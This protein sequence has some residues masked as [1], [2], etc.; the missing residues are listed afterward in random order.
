MARLGTA[1]YLAYQIYRVQ[2]TVRESLTYRFVVPG[3]FVSVYFQR[4]PR[5]LVYILHFG[6]SM[7]SLHEMVRYSDTNWI[8]QY[9]DLHQQRT[10]RP[11][12]INVLYKNTDLALIPGAAMI[13][14]VGILTGGAVYNGHHIYSAAR[15]YVMFPGETK[16]T[17]Y[18][19]TDLPTLITDMIKMLTR[20]KRPYADSVYPVSDKVLRIFVQSSSDSLSPSDSDSDHS[21]TA[22]DSSLPVM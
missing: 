18:A 15:T 12:Q 2:S 1:R 13:N 8:L 7:Y 20:P 11:D 4:I 5:Y 14:R 17:P 3:V 6:K 22:E 19:Y 21:P 16:V 10:Y 9:R